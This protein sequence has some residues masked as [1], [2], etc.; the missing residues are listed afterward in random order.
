MSSESAHRNAAVRRGGRPTREEAARRDIRLLDVATRLFM[1]NGYDGTS[2]DAVAEAAGV[3][4]P[5]LY[6]RYKDKRD[7]FEAVL[8]ERIE[9]WI[10]PLAEAAESL[11]GGAESGNIEGVLDQLS[12][13]M[14]RHALKPGAAALTRVIAA[15]KA[16]F[17]ELA[18]LAYRQGWLRAVEAVASILR[19]FAAREPLDIPDA[20]LAAE[21]FLNLIMGTSSRAALY[22]VEIDPDGLEQRR[23]GA[24]R[25]FLRGIGAARKSSEA[26][27]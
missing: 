6:H 27:P 25:L 22:G 9:Q 10:S 16:Q 11:N 1:E 5:T 12:R 19:A 7:L 13:A 26:T 8:T 14:L 18:Q 24:V 17:P 23:V 3:G 2:M 20:R 21:L 4:K 15:Q